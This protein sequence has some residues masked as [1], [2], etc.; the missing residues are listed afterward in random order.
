V[1]D[2]ITVV[3]V[4]RRRV[5]LLQRCI[6]SVKNQSCKGSVQHLIITDDCPQTI[7][8]L[9][10]SYP[11]DSKLRH[12]L[13]K[14]SPEERSGPPRLARLR[15]Y[16]NRLVETPWTAFLDDDNEYEVN[17]LFS[18]LQCVAETGCPA[19]HSHRKLVCFE[20]TPFLEPR[21][22]W[23]RD[24]QQ[25]EQ[26]YQE[27][28][29]KGVMQAGSNIIRDRV[30]LSPGRSYIMLVDTSEWLIKTE[31]LQSIR[32]PETFSLQDWLDN[33]AEDDKLVEALVSSRIRIA[34]SELPSLKYYLGGY[35]NDFDGKYPHSEHWLFNGRL[36]A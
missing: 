19:V 7:S 13:V 22:P 6:E 26:R 20:G 34:C 5:P 28:V 23:C 4:T 35:S 33:L 16:A 30:D 21:W 32:I 1:D 8:W 10:C 3:T 14:R 24:R 18:L 15:N 17:H 12:Q 11:S 25:G 29:E 9:A 31:V 27:L 2:S 36:T